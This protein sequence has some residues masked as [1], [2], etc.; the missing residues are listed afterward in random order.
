MTCE[1]CGGH[2]DGSNMHP[3]WCSCC[4]PDY[5]DPPYEPRPWPP[6]SAC[7]QDAVMTVGDRDLCA[8]CYEKEGA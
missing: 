6:C 5:E 3:Y 1:R 8:V 4:A 7:G 2:D